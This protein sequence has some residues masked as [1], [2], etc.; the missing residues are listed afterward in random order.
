M[1]SAI[2]SVALPL[3]L[4]C[5]AKLVSAQTLL[6][7][8]G[9]TSAIA[10][11]VGGFASFNFSA[12][13]AKVGHAWQVSTS[14]LSLGTE[15]SAAAKDGT[16]ELFKNSVQVG[17]YE[18]G[19]RGAYQLTRLGERDRGMLGQW[20]TFGLTY[21]RASHSLIDTLATSVADTLF[22][23]VTAGVGYNAFLGLGKA[24]EVV[25]GAR[26]SYGSVDNAT[27]LD[28]AELCVE[29]SR[30]ATGP[31]GVT[32]TCTPGS[33]GSYRSG[34]G[35]G[36]DVNVLWYQRWAKNRLGLTGFLRWDEFLGEMSGG[37]GVVVTASGR[38]LEVVGGAHLERKAGA[39]LLVF[40]AGLP[41][42]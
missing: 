42:S 40:Q 12:S 13:K 16:A 6:E 37:P 2:L 15:L 30:A 1:R 29:H 26:V 39:W 10:L 21:T 32:Q 4:L 7:S 14:R 24:G 33:L 5:G 3:A 35:A 17:E 27:G 38:P 28:E 8:S 41:F 9:G 20:I 25:A 19:F 18:V 34:K 22:R 31:V 23:G 11:P 36:L